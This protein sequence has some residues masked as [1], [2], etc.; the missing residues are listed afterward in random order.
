MTCASCGAEAERGLLC[1]SCEHWLGVI[2][3]RDDPRSVRIGGTAYWIGPETGLPP[4]MRGFG[5]QR[6]EIA[7]RD[8]RRTETRN[9]WCEGTIPARFR[10]RLPDNAASSGLRAA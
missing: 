3:R 5:G 4:R 8:G 9:L 2:A 6:F 7:F 1:I 10:G